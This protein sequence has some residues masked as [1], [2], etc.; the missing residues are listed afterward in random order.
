MKDG[1]DVDLERTAPQWPTTTTQDEND[2]SR[3]KLAKI[4]ILVT[5]LMRDELAWLDVTTRRHAVASI[6]GHAVDKAERQNTM[7][8]G[9]E[10]EIGPDTVKPVS[11][12]REDARGCRHGEFYNTS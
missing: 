1:G 3:F 2:H 5:I 12:N 4:D 8:F 10:T 9:N 6:A 7:N 11:Y